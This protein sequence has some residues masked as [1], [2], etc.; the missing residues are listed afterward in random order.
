V[1]EKL[2]TKRRYAHELYPH[3][4]E[5]EIRPLAVEVPY[6]YARALGFRVDG[7][8][9]FEPFRDTTT[10]EVNREVAQRSG[11]RTNLMIYARQRALLADALLQGLSGEEAWAWAEEHDDVEGEWVWER[12]V[13]Y[14]VDP[15]AIRP[16]PCG[17]EPDHHDHWTP[18]DAN[19]VRTLIGH[20][21]VGKE[22]DCA[23]C[24]VPL[25]APVDQEGERP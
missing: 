17:P 14:G 13:H 5:G 12:A 4:D 24:C 6:L 9:W 8:S 3:P 10:G 18:R 23:N 21:V 19:G 16:Y 25:V 22:S 15:D 20:R 7:T 11:D 2:Q 1:T